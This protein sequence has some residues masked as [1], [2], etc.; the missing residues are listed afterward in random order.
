MFWVLFLFLTVAG[1]FDVLKREIPEWLTLPFLAGGLIYSAVEGKLVVALFS[2]L[3]SFAFAYVPY[4]SGNLGGG[5]VMVLLAVSSWMPLTSGFPTGVVLL[6]FSLFMGGVITL[7]Y[8]ALRLGKSKDR[9]WYLLPLPLFLFPIG[10]AIVYGFI[11]AYIL[12]MKYGRELFW[13]EKGVEELEPEDVLVGEYPC[14]P[15]G[16]KVVGDRDIERLRRCGVKEVVV[17][18]G[19]PPFS[20]AILL[21]FVFLTYGDLSILMK[22]PWQLLQ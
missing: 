19:L 20:P 7:I 17:L 21:A 14:L 9:L 22:W 5:D 10:V 13:R 1:A 6:S 16:R 15:K 12:G 3:V 11:T 2:I 4:Y 8:L 18:E